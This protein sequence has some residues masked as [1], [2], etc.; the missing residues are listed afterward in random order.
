MASE[1]AR[2]KAIFH[3]AAEAGGPGERARILDEACAGDAALHERV[4]ALLKAHDQADRLLDCAAVEHLS[5]DGGA[6]DELDTPG[7]PAEEITSLE[8]LSPSQ[9][10]G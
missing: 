3:A 1:T 10:P 4:V 7:P 2:I 8:F 9:K 5:A 6:K